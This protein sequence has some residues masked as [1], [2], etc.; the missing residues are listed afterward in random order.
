MSGHSGN[1]LSLALSQDGRRLAS[2]SAD[3]TIRVWD[4]TE[5]VPVVMART[6]GKVPS[7]AFSPGGQKLLSASDDGSLLISEQASALAERVCQLVWRNYQ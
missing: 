1:V 6:Q 4:L 2:G 7:M 5:T 3:R